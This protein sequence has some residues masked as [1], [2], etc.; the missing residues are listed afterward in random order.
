MPNKLNAAGRHHIPK[1]R[2]RVTNWAEYEAGL[3]RRGSLTMWVTEDAIAAW[4]AAPRTTSGGQATYSDSA[5]QACL[6]LRAAFKL[7]LRQAEGLMLSVV[8]MLGIELGVP[9]HST[10]SRRSARLESIARDSLPSGPLH[11]LIDSTGL[12]VFGAGEWL[13]DKHGRRSR[14]TYRK[15]HL[16][17]DAH[18][19]QIVACLLTD[20]DTDDPSQVVPLL[21][22][23]PGEI[24]QITADGAY[25]GEPTYQ[26]IA[27]RD[28]AIA[29]VIPPRDTAVPSPQFECDAS[30]RDTHLLT[31][32]SL[33]RLAWQQVTGYGRR[34]L[35]ETTMGRYK[36]IIG[37]RLRARSDAAQRTEVAIGAAVLNRML[38]AARPNPVRSSVTPG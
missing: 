11:V 2:H 9:D 30:A 32:E 29:V 38:A 10:V 13:A 5:I 12:K 33:G 6:M 31:I 28:A 35:V 1:M 37:A 15:L 8:E 14:R 25:D 26:T 7:P 24:D 4:A 20:Q 18:S 16:G 34:A 21:E 3:R 27:V 36:L 22:Q 17:V 19:G 23:I